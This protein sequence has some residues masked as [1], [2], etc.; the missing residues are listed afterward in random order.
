MLTRSR[1]VRG[2]TR[3]DAARLEHTVMTR[4]ISFVSSRSCGS[5]CLREEGIVRLF[6][7]LEAKPSLSMSHHPEVLPADLS[8]AIELLRPRLGGL[9]SKVFFFSTIGSTNDFAAS[10]AAAGDAEGTVVIADQQTAGRGRRG[11]TWFSPPGAGLYVS[12]V[13]RPARARVEPDR[14]TALIT[15]AAG[16][17][18]AE[19]V[20]RT[21]G[22]RAE[23]KWPN[24]LLV[25]PRK[26]AGILA[27]GVSAPMSAAVQSVVLGYGL[28]V[29][30]LH[31]PPDLAARVTSLESELGRPVDRASLGAETLAALAARYRDLLDARFDAILD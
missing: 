11:R 13:L 2:R 10:L 1:Q 30:A 7:S 14:A 29:S 6:R 27:E 5:S 19:A 23:I 8:N 22:L 25:G 20:E 28:N 16:V 24:D 17:A 3:R 12:V 26:L 18:L 9:A 4:R 31:P 15:L 21:T